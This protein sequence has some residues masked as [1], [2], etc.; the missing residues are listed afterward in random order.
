MLDVSEAID[1]EA[2]QMTL[3]TRSHGAYNDRG[4]FVPGA[5]TSAPFMG[6]IFPIGGR[7]LNDMPEGIR[8]EAS[9]MLWTRTAIVTD[10]QVLDGLT[11]YRVLHVWDRSFEGGFFKA[12][13]GKNV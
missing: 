5:L 3:Q 6:A 1:A 11:S 12:A 13:L 7:E 9:Q 2:R 8:V 4:N 10:T